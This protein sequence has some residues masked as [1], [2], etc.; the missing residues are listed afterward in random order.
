M[1]ARQAGKFPR[2]AAARADD[3][4]RPQPQRVSVGTDAATAGRA[5]LCGPRISYL[6]L[7]PVAHGSGSSADV[8]LDRPG[9]VDQC[10]VTAKDRA[11]RHEVGAESEVVGTLEAD[12]AD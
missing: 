12:P 10:S 3:L 2:L 6:Q 7:P 1:P 8:Q 11:E 9:A 5:T 4:T